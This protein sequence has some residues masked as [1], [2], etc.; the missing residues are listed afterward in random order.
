M[1]IELGDSVQFKLEVHNRTPYQV[2]EVWYPILGGITGLGNRT[3]TQVM[4]GQAGAS[5]NSDMFQR[6]R[7]Q[8]IEEL[9]VPGPE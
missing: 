4:I 9:G 1:T 2:A 8:G 3:D 5:T 6:F 7:G